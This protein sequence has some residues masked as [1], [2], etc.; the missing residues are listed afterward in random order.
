M[1]DTTTA[2]AGLTPPGVPSVAAGP[3]VAAVGGVDPESVL[4]AARI[5][6][7][8]SAAGV[9]AVAVLPSL[10]VSIPGE[11]AWMIPSGYEEER[12]ADCMSQLTTR[13]ETFGGAATSWGR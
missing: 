6:A 5:L 9:V 3:I 7:P 8:A 10:P 1:T 11:T 4:R 12:F 13:L 2:Q